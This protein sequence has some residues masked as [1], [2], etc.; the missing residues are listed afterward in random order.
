M[1]GLREYQAE[2]ERGDAWALFLARL[3]GGNIG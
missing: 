2:F 1:Y 3:L